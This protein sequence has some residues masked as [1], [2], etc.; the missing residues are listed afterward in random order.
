LTPRPPRLIDLH[1]DWIL[2]YAPETTVFDPALYPTVPDRLPQSEGYLHGTWIAVLSCY[3]NADD[4]ASQSD[5]WSALGALLTRI[6][7]EFPGRLL[8]GPAD[9]A[10]CLDDPEGLCWGMIGVEG[11]DALVRGPG[12]LDRLPGLFA[13]GVRLFQP[14][15]TATGVLAG[16]SAPGDDRGLTDLGRSFLDVLSGLG[17]DSDGPRPLFDLAHLNPQSASDVLDWFESDGDRA[18]RVIPVYSHGA[19]RHDGFTTPRA[20]TPESLG[21]LRALG[22]V[23]GFGVS[24][25]FYASPGEIKAGIEA[26]AAIPFL[27][28][29]GFEGIAIGTDFLGVSRTLP[30]LGNVPE[31]VAW[32][33]ST[34]D[35]GT[36]SALLQGN[37]RSLVERVL[38]VGRSRTC[39]ESST[40]E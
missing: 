21:R 38:G 36:A 11:F 20:I 27:G 3:R 31:V 22:G 24:P 12:D 33:T 4:W 16:S 18:S 13:R 10:R 40:G 6:E 39:R 2:Q 9:L 30:G 26:A 19:L 17:A 29:E 23:I 34:F 14:S 28:R 25:P 7:A 32:I 5:P 1:T 8:I 15:Y 37:A 35:A